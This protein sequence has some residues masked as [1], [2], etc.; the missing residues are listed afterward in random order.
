M[1]PD[2]PPP[3]RLRDLAIDQAVERQRLEALIASLEQLGDRWQRHGADA[4]RVDAAAL[5]LQ[6]LYTG[7]ERCLLQ[8]VRV[9]NG[10]SPEGA[11]W[12]RRLLDR[13]TQPTERRP[14]L[15]SAATARS[16]G[17]LLGF[18]HVVRHL[19]ADDLDPLQVRQR[20]D[21]ALDLWPQL[22][23][24][25]CVIR[26]NLEQQ[27]CVQPMKTERLAL[28]VSDA[29]LE[30]L[31]QLAEAEGLSRAEVVRRAVALLAFAKKEEQEGRRMGFFVEEAGV[32]RIKE[33]V[34]L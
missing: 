11:D 18:R 22:H 9:L 2:P 6:S 31:D 21:G 8:I 5:R 20:L 4:E 33:V 7:I 12:H 32:P 16:L 13:L 26:H 15:L 14:A 27:L 1:L 19:Y 30:G 29:F 23:A 10:G 28:R 3:S 34:A 25:S 24:S 17:Q